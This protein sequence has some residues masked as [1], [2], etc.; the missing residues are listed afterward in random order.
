MSRPRS[1]VAALV[2]ALCVAALLHAPVGAA[3]AGEQQPRSTAVP[4]R[5]PDGRLSSYV[6]NAAQPWGENTRKVRRAVRRTGGVVVQAWPRIGVVVAHSRRGVFRD[7]LRSRPFVGS[8]GATRTFRVLEGT[9]GR[10]G[11][12]PRARP[13]APAVVKDEY[14]PVDAGQVEPDPHESRQWDMEVVKADQAH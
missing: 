7:A 2:V 6:V 3:T 1:A 12:A 5:T 10:A 14:R 9:P 11:D 8:V 13:A 4:M